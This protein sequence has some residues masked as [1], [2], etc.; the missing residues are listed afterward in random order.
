VD[1]PPLGTTD[2]GGPLFSDEI[3]VRIN[4]DGEADGYRLADSLS[5]E[6]AV[7]HLRDTDVDAAFVYLGD[8]D[9]VAHETDSH[10][11]QYRA[12]IE[13]AD[14]RVGLL[15]QALR[16]RPTYAQED[17]LILMSTDHGRN[18]AGG[19]GGTSPSET[20]I[21]YLASGPSVEA[22]RTEC[23]PEIVDVAVT[24]LTHMGLTPAPEWGLDGRA[25]GLKE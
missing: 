20:T 19:H 4:F 2:S 10:S 24:A 3:D 14:T 23:P 16:D 17:W 1:W 15:L 18:D 22:G 13:W 11:K 7:E 6:A 12:A 25:R 21:F 8:I 9:V 5:V